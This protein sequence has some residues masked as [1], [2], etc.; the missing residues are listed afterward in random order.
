MNPYWEVILLASVAISAVVGVG[1]WYALYD[2]F[3]LLALKRWW[4]MQ[5][6]LLA[7]RPIYGPADLHRCKGPHAKPN[8]RMVR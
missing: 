1:V 6:G 2:L 4:R 8:L 7:Q 3:Y 5:L